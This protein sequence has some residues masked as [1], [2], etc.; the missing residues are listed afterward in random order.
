MPEPLAIAKS[1]KAELTPSPGMAKHHRDVT[2]DTGAAK[3]LTLA[4]SAEVVART[5]VPVFM[6]DVKGDFSRGPGHRRSGGRNACASLG[7]PSH[8]GGR[9][10]RI[11][12]VWRAGRAHACLGIQSRIVACLL[13][14]GATQ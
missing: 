6:A 1:S 4:V 12:C 9:A 5:A 14:L 3:T 13:T 11:G 10:R 2:A 7:C 8:S